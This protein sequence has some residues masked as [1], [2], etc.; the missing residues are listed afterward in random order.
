MFGVFEFFFRP[1]LG[2]LRISEVSESPISVVFL[3]SLAAS[4]VDVRRPRVWVCGIAMHNGEDREAGF[5]VRR[6]QAL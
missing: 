4:E 5:L 6:F 1:L 3:G 2:A